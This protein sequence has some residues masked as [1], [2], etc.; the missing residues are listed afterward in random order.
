VAWESIGDL[1]AELEHKWTKSG[2]SNTLGELSNKLA[3]LS[4]DLM[5]WGVQTVG[6]INVQIRKL[7]SELEELRNTPDRPGPSP[8]E[9]GCWK[10][11]L[12]FLRRRRSCGDKDREWN[13]SQ[14]G[15]KIPVFSTCG[16]ASVDRKIELMN[17]EEEMVWW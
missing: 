8:R 10:S 17:Y 6:N 4:D 14:R 11:W 2:K 13:G 7:Q 5:R 9:S 3:T 1:S 12:Y 15:I 16:L